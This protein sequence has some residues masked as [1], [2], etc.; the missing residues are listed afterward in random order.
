MQSFSTLNKKKIPFMFAMIAAIFITFILLVLL[1]VWLVN[2]D[3]PGIEGLIII[4]LATGIS[5]PAFLLV[6][7]YIGW[8]LDRRVRIKILKKAPFDQLHEIGFVATYIGSDTNYA[9]TEETLGA[10]ILGYYIQFNI[11]RGAPRKVEFIAFVYHTELEK[12]NFNQ[13]ESKF[14]KEDVFFD[15][16]GLIKKY[17]LRKRSDL[18]IEQLEK[19]LILF[20]EELKAEGFKPRIK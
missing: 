6:I 11:E 5:M 18:T 12:K 16:D 17:D 9:F 20:V 1:I 4:V 19:D 15:F 14:K 2:D 8:Y 13:L 10:T 7:G 3:F